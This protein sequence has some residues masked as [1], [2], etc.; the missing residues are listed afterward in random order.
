V[1]LDLWSKFCIFDIL[2]LEEYVSQ[3]KGGPHMF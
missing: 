1:A 2:V 3:I